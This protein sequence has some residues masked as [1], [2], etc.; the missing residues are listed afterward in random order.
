MW[1]TSSLRLVTKGHKF[2]RISFFTFLSRGREGRRERV[3]LY[4]VGKASS[5]IQRLFPRHTPGF[6]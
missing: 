6:E 2:L 1:N 3:L 5:S 4:A